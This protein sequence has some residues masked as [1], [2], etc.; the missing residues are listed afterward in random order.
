ML[1]RRENIMI[2]SV[3][4]LIVVQDVNA[5]VQTWDGTR[6][7]MWEDEMSMHDNTSPQQMMAAA[8]QQVK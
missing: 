8:P 6:L 2:L 4:I 7:Y 5:K 1:S 3:D